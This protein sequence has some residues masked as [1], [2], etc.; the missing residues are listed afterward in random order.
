[1]NGKHEKCTVVWLY[2]TGLPLQSSWNMSILANRDFK[3]IDYV[4]LEINSRLPR[5][6]YPSLAS[7]T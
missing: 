7:Y 5:L 2:V 1:M 6:G 3:K 4:P